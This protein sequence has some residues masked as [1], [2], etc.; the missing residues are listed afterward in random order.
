VSKE[1]FNFRKYRD[2]SDD[3]AQ[4]N[5]FKDC[6]PETIGT[7][8][9]EVPHYR[10]KFKSFPSAVTSYEYV[11]ESSDG[12]LG[13]YAAIPYRYMIGDRVQTVGMV[14]DVMT[15]TRSR[16]QGIFTKLGSFATDQMRRENLDFTTGY[17]I[18]PAVIPGHLKVG[19]KIAF[20]LPMYIRVLKCDSLLKNSAFKVLTPLLNVFMDFFRFLIEFFSSPSAYV[21]HFL[22]SSAFFNESKKYAVFFDSWKAS[23]KNYLIKD[24]DFLKWRTG[25]PGASYRF[26]VVEN[27]GTWIAVAIVRHTV[28]K[29]IPS[30]AILDL[31]ILDLH[32]N[33]RRLITR[34]FSEEA[35]RFRSEAI[36]IMSSRAAAK[37]LGLL[38]MGFIPTPAVFRLIIK[39][40]NSSLDDLSLFSESRWQLGWIDSDDL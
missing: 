16:G 23:Q 12:M 5:L 7:P 36:V 25:A 17:P 27:N 11:T 32:L 13:Y 15:S 18:R 40:L 20:K 35:K 28:L 8:A 34:A 24:V 1:E 30:L 9:E 38:L 37:K 10:W 4:R 21:A 31:M 39:K 2:G 6:F 29:G 3:L 33:A 22:D 19:W 14:C 26:L